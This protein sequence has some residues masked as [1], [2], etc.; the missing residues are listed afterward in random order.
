MGLRKKGQGVKGGEGL[1][2]VGKTPYTITGNGKAWRWVR[3]GQSSLPA[4]G[5]QKGGKG[6]NMGGGGLDL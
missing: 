5:Q 6:V 3:T 2:R 1:R 4:R